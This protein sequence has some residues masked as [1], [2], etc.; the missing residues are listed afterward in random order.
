MNGETG[1]S[2]FDAVWLWRCG[3]S[4]ANNTTSDLHMDRIIVTQRPMTTIAERIQRTCSDSSSLE[5][6]TTS[7]ESVER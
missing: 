6:A 1:I 7:S 4:T 2:L 3:L 5:D